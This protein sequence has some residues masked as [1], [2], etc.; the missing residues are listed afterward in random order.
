M[1]SISAANTI[2][3]RHLLALNQKIDFLAVGGRQQCGRQISTSPVL[4]SSTT[5]QSQLKTAISDAKVL[6]NVDKLVSQGSEGRL[7]AIVQICGKQFRVTDGDI[8]LIEGYWA[9][10]IGDKLRLDKVLVAGGKEFS[11]IGTPIL[12]PGVVDVQATVIEKSFTHTKTNF[13]KKKTKQY[14]RIN[15]M[16]NQIT[17]LMINS[18]ELKSPIRKAATEMK[19]PEMRIF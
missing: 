1:S 8:I 14:M 3:R 5:E 11:L 2:S 19:E 10:T 13:K 15:F 4:S 9:P 16:R 7:F 6:E 18:V 12:E 17:M